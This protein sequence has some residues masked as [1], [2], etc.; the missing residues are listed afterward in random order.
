MARFNSSLYEINQAQKMRSQ[1]EG[2]LLR[3]KTRHICR[4][5]NMD[6]VETFSSSHSIVGYFK[7][8]HMVLITSNLIVASN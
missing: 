4:K 5:L 7:I 2:L 6:K 3:T 1:S 8:W